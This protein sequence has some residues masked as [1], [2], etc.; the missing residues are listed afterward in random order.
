LQLEAGKLPPVPRAGFAAGDEGGRGARA[1]RYVHTSGTSSQALGWTGTSRDGEEIKREW[2]RQQTVRRAVDSLKRCGRDKE[3][4][5]LSQCGERF[6]VWAKRTGECKLLPIRCDSPFC[7]ECARRRSLPLIKKLKGMVNKPDCSYWHLVLT[8]PNV[9]NLSKLDILEFQ[10][11]WSKLWNSW[12]FQEVEDETGKPFRIFG[13]VRSIEVTYNSE[14]K[15][16][17][18]HIH[19]LFEAPRRLPRWWLVLLKH[20]WMQLTGD[21]RYLHLQRAYSY[22]KRGERKRSRLNGKALREVCKYVTKCADFAAHPFLVDEFL[23]AFKDVRRVQCC[24]SFFGPKAAEF[25]RQPG[26]DESG[27]APTETT[28]RGEGYQRMPWDVPIRDTVLLG[29][30]SRQLSF[31]FQERV[32]EHFASESPPW[33]LTPAP[34]VSSEQK[35]IEFSGAMPEKSELQSWL[36]EGAA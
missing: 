22:T 28:L 11:L 30:G 19:V 14:L 34:V 36:F 31:A 29:D 2:Q 33:E 1:A 27:I 20:A 13:A 26:E 3:A 8:A 15:S 4:Q 23:K 17:H 9:E 12:V 24:G 16:W 25:G 21:S 6:S 7:S 10:E 32:R 18:P 35:R 5:N